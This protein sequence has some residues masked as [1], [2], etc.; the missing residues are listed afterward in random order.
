MHRTS[1][2]DDWGIID[3]SGAWTAAPRLGLTSTPKTER[4]P[5]L[6]AG[7]LVYGSGQALSGA[8]NATI[9]GW[10]NAQGVW[11]ASWEW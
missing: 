4:N 7:G 1:R 9:Q 10:L 6:A 11:I 2:P 3:D 8:T 5:L